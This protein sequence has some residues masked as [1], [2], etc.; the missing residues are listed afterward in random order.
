MANN[1]ENGVE[2]YRIVE[3]NLSID[4]P[5]RTSAMEIKGALEHYMKKFDRHGVLGVYS[6][7]VELNE[8]PN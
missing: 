7:G 2:K 4:T 6:V 3:V 1:C 8:N 5:E